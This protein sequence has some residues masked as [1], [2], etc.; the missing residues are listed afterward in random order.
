MI[1]PSARRD[2]AIFL[3]SSREYI[4][5]RDTTLPIKHVSNLLSLAWFHQNLSHVLEAI[6][7]FRNYLC[8]HPSN[9]IFYLND[10]NSNQISFGEKS[11]ENVIF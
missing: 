7:C 4:L 10:S 9:F 5:D 1:F 6:I 3:I 2:E 11:E 8:K